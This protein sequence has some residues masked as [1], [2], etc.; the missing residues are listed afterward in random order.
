MSYPV[1]IPGGR[2][3]QVGSE[4]FGLARLAREATLRVPGV[5]RTDPGP[6]GLFVTVGGGERL[7]GVRCVAT[8]EGGYEISLRLVC[9][10]VPL[11]QLGDRVKAA[12]L[13]TAAK[14][15]IAL[16]SVSVHV[17][18]VAGPEEQ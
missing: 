16:E 17:A 14:A 8:K 15:G 10:L 3:P 13:S 4:R 6:T 11:P 9:A 18:A 5:V 2:P 12:V 7:E 1:D